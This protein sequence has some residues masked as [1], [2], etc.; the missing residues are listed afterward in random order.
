LAS[1]GLT[2]SL[3]VKQLAFFRVGLFELNAIGFGHLDHFRPGGFQQLGFYSVSHSFF[4]D[5]RVHDDEGQFFLA[6]QLE[7]ERYL[8]GAGHQFF[9]AL[10]AQ[11]FTE[12]PQLCWPLV[13]KIFAYR[14]VLPRGDLAPALDHVI[15]NLVERMPYVQQGHHQPVG[16]KRPAGTGN[17]TTGN[18]RNRAKQVQVFDLLASFDLPSP[19]P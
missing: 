16:Q 5:R 4:F 6:D 9:N 11:S 12:P 3:V 1:L 18:D 14:K 17:A 15:V 10:L 13:L 8:H 7:G 2:P 19:A